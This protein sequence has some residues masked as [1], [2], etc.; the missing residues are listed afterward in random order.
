VFLHHVAEPVVNGW[1]LVAGNEEAKLAVAALDEILSLSTHLNSQAIVYNNTP[2]SAEAALTHL[3]SVVQAGNPI[4]PT[5]L[6]A[7]DE[8]SFRV[9]EIADRASGVTYRELFG[10]YLAGATWI[11][12][13]DPYIRQ[14]YQVENLEDFLGQMSLAKPCQV[15]LTTMY[16]EYPRYGSSS[17]RESKQR[18]DQLN[19]RLAATGAIQF[20]YKFDPTI[21][22]RLIQ[23]AG[24][25]IIPGRGLDI[26][27]PPEDGERPAKQCQIVYL[28]K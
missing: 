22:D 27:Y 17:E 24:W 1:H 23:T 5:T 28:R 21:H 9:R 19:Q 4:T 3:R 8:D 25:Q 10:E 2:T 14:A 16:D 15:E 12:I 18:L 11:K 26:Y 13:A 6:R 7:P 20:S